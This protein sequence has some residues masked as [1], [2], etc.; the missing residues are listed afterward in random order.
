MVLSEVTDFQSQECPLTLILKPA[1]MLF[2]HHF[3]H[4]PSQKF[5]S[6]ARGQKEMMVF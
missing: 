1:E 6:K 4:N 3:L 5:M 2:Y